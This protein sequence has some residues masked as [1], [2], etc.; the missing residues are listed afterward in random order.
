M[1]QGS[2]DPL[3]SLAEQV[4]KLQETVVE[5][6]VILHG[7]QRRARLAF[8]ASTLKWVVIIGISLGSFYFLQPIFESTLRVYENLSLQG[9]LGK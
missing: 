2:I 1:E 8:L 7:L 9:V 4:K 6:N 3:Q 5:N